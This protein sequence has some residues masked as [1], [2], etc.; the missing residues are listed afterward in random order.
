M[1]KVEGKNIPR[2]VP[3]WGFSF[4][5]CCCD[6]AGVWLFVLSGEEDPVTSLPS[7]PRTA[8]LLPRWLMGLV[9]FC[10]FSHSGN[11]NDAEERKHT[12]SHN[13]LR[14]CA[15]P[16][17]SGC[18]LCVRH[19]ASAGQFGT[20]PTGKGG[21]T[22]QNKSMDFTE[23]RLMLSCKIWRNG[24]NKKALTHGQMDRNIM[25]NRWRQSVENIFWTTEE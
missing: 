12:K 22:L 18:F 25:I 21:L 1:R 4:V 17:E 13:P 23:V 2:I 7:A 15:L 10:H 5:S 20:T 3:H 11:M 24:K 19:A 8:P 16:A 9:V 6:S 14:C